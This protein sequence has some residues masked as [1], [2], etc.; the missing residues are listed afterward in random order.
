MKLQISGK[1]V[2]L[3]EALRSRIN[4]ELVSSIG[5]YFGRGGDADVVVS[6]SGHSFR[7]DCAVRLAS[8]QGLESHALGEDA[9]AAFDGALTDRHPVR[10]YKRRLKNHHHASPTGWT[11]SPR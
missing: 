8:G 1:H 10:R 3:G 6:R 4:D 9:H 5:K 2:E 7:V 11:K